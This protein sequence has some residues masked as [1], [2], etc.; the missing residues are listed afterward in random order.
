MTDKNN[1]WTPLP[2]VTAAMKAGISAEQ[3]AKD[4]SE[5]LRLTGICT[6]DAPT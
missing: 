2:T 5:L 6:G 3:V 1:R 4:I